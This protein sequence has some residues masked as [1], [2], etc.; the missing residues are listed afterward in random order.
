M[1]KQELIWLDTAENPEGQMEL[2]IKYRESTNEE[3]VAA[4][5]EISSNKT[6]PE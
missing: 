2:T 6:L 4:F 5:L 1:R 3:N